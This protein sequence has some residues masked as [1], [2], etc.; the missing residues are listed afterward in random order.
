MGRE[1]DDMHQHRLRTL[2]DS[3]VIDLSAD[4][5]RVAIRSKGLWMLGKTDR[6]AGT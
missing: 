4:E 1:P 6:P 5:Q 2:W 3:E